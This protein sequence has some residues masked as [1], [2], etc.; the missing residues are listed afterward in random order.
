MNKCRNL[1]VVNKIRFSCVWWRC[2]R[3]HAHRVH[4]LNNNTISC[5]I[6]KRIR[7][8]LPQKISMW[9]WPLRCFCVDIYIVKSILW[10]SGGNSMWFR[11]P[12]QHHHWK[13][14]IL[15]WLMPGSQVEFICD[16]L[17]YLFLCAPMQCTA[18]ILPV[19]NSLL[20][21]FFSLLF[22][23]YDVRILVLISFQWKTFGFWKHKNEA[24]V[25]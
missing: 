14:T 20:S 7:W 16:L 8:F 11:M 18:F 5:T 15:R 23:R 21:S 3:T 22:S 17:V 6:D 19:R 24:R 9:N 4:W 12:L 2:A 13:Y 1:C 25:R 10:V